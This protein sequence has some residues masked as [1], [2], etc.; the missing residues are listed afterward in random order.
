MVAQFIM[1]LV[2]VVK[3]YKKPGIIDQNW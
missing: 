1:N 3:S 2:I